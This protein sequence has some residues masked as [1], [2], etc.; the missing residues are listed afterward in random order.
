MAE[1]NRSNLDPSDGRKFLDRLESQHIHIK[2]PFTAEFGIVL[3]VVLGV[4]PFALLSVLGNPVQ[5]VL[6]LLV[7]STIMIFANILFEYRNPRGTFHHHIFKRGWYLQACNIWLAEITA[8][9][10]AHGWLNLTIISGSLLLFGLGWAIHDLVVRHLPADER[11]FVYKW[12]LA[13]SFIGLGVTSLI[14]YAAAPRLATL[15]PIL[16]F[17]TGI[18]AFWSQV[19]T[20]RNELHANH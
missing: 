1:L 2:L 6:I 11:L 19:I 20:A 8:V 17:T 13:I 16:T 7:L 9:T 12:L 5:F 14:G 3:T 18:A 4:T 10:M 15:F